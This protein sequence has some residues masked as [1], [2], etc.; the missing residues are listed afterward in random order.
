[1]QNSA[2]RLSVTWSPAQ[3]LL[4]SVGPWAGC[5]VDMGEQGLVSALT[6]LFIKRNMT[7]NNV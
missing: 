4:D 5:C 7:P 1:M 3:L 6:E 2:F